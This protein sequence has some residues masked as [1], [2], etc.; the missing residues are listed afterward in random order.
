[1][2]LT[3]FCIHICI[4]KIELFASFKEEQKETERT[5]FRPGFFIVIFL[6]NKKEKDEHFFSRTVGKGVADEEGIQTS[7]LFSML[8]PRAK[9]NL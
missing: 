7:T 8:K 2:Q 3:V 4:F 9:C 5:Y 6:E 1:M